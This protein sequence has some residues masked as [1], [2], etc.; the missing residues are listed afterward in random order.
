MAQVNIT[1]N[2]PAYDN[3]LYLSR[4]VI[5]FIQAAG[6]GGVSLKYVAQAN[7]NAYS[8]NAYCTTAGTSTYTFTQNALS[9][10]AIASQQLSLITIVNT[11]AL[12]TTVGLSTST[13]GPFVM[14]GS[15]F[16]VSGTATN[17]VGQ[18]TQNALNTTSQG[19]RG[20]VTIP[21]GAQFY[22]VNGTDATA[23]FDVTLECGYQALTNVVA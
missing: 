19:A 13:Y 2:S 22:I 17:Q 11:A 9:T 18:Y 16:I 23:I 1:Q 6:S 12:G 15:S 7:L 21:Q 8:I 3:P 4:F 14:T 10:I 5:P 20:G